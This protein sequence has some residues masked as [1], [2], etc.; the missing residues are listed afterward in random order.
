MAIELSGFA[1]W[2]NPDT[3]YAKTH[4]SNMV[5]SENIQTPSLFALYCVVVILNGYILHINRQSVTRN[6]K[7]KFLQL[8]K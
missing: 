8:Y 3:S 7:V 2:V 1:V 5:A 4:L 6:A